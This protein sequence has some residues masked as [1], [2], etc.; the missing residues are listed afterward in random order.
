MG[1]GEF[2]S[3]PVIE[4]NYQIIH[5][6]SQNVFLDLVDRFVFDPLNL[7]YCVEQLDKIKAS[8]SK[9]FYYVPNIDWRKRVIRSIVEDSA[10][11]IEALRQENKATKETLDD[12]LAER[13]QNEV[14]FCISR[15]P[16][17]NFNHF[18]ISKCSTFME[19]VHFTLLLHPNQFMYYILLRLDILDS[20]LFFA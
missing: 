4:K 5:H 6:E 3:P 19:R 8:K 9:H 11:S 14:T 20:L 12:I 18:R 1:R 7:K 13:K 2:I 10:I 15:P 17:I 16:E